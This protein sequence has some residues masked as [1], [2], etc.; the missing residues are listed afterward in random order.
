MYR[1]KQMSLR[2]RCG[3]LACSIN[4]VVSHILVETLEALDMRFP[5]P[6]FDVSRIELD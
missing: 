6:T 1:G 5:K 3:T 4:F 2:S